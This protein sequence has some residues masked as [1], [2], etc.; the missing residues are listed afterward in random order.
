MNGLNGIKIIEAHYIGN[1]GKE[2]LGVIN[3]ATNPEPPNPPGEKIELPRHFTVVFSVLF[4][5]N[6]L[7]L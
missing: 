4:Y 6:E 1:K 2:I 7:R 3:N 5:N